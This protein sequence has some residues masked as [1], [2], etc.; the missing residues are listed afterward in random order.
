MEKREAI[1]GNRAEEFPRAMQQQALERQGFV[2]ASC[3]ETIRALGEPGRPDNRF[4]EIGHAHHIK[5]AKFGGRAI[6]E[7]CVIICQSCHYSAHEGGN[8]RWGTV[9]G[10][11]EDFP[12]FKK[13][14]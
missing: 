13:K 7:N 14:K 10:K 2:C 4:G 5:H 1:M 8:Y 6:V 3:G 12:F 9:V 11:T